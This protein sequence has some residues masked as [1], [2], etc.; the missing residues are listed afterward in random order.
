MSSR[1][2][3]SPNLLATPCEFS[4]IKIS[5]RHSVEKPYYY[6]GPLPPDQ[7]PERDVGCLLETASLKKVSESGCVPESFSYRDRL[8]RL[9]A[10]IFGVNDL[11]SWSIC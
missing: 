3:L 8:A 11:N 4:Y 1:N 5:D 10:T 9:G 7:H 6:S 2:P